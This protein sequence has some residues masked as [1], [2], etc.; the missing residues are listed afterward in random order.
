MGET[1]EAL[2][3]AGRGLRVHEAVLAGLVCLGLALPFVSLPGLPGGE[4]TRIA[5]RYRTEGM[6]KPASF[7]VRT[8]GD[9]CAVLSLALSYQDSASGNFMRV[10]CGQDSNALAAEIRAERKASAATSY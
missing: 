2:G 10:E 3:L 1:M 7:I 9:I 6:E 5:V 8:E 4:L